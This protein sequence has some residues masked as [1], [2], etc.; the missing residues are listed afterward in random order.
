MR[1]RH[2]D[3][4]WRLIEVVGVNLLAEPAVAGIVATMRDMTERQRLEDQLRQAQKM[5]AIGQ[6]AGGVAHDFNNLLT[7]IMGFAE[8]LR[9]QLSPDSS[10]RNAIDQI[11][12]S[13]ESAA[14]LTRQ[15]LAFSRRQIIAPQEI[16]LNALVT[17]LG[18]MLRRIIGD[19][20]VFTTAL[21][22]VGVVEADPGQ[23]EQVLLNLAANARDA[24][25]RGGQL[26]IETTSVELDENDVGQHAGT[27]PGHYVLLAVRDTG[28]GMDV[29]TQ[30]RIFEP[31]FTT[32]EVGQGTGLGLAA[33]YGIIKQSGGFI[34]VASEIG[35]G[36]TFKVYLPRAAAPTPRSKPPAQIGRLEGTET[37]LVVED[38]PYLRT[39]MRATFA[40]SRHTVLEAESGARA[41]EIAAEYPATIDLLVT[42]VVMPGLSGR[43]VAE[44][45]RVHRPGLKVL[46]MSGYTDDLV[47]RHGVM[48]AEDNFLQKPF[49]PLSLTQKVRQVLDGPGG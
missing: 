35:H 7:V 41:L 17:R 15:L 44:Q 18:Q 25:P 20:I 5:E 33:V 2:A 40:G 13:S 23:I 37:I 11:L 43:D 12:I 14:S 16:D 32:K 31:F 30:A 4:S 26:T 36:T 28:I 6:L 9:L 22:P 1:C 38:D 45:L 29:A 49:R 21:G 47:V 8:I 19:D 42:D 3:G 10:L 39:L 46:Y 27:P 24:M 48:K 34:D